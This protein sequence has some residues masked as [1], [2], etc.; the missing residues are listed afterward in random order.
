M[1]GPAGAGIAL[2]GIRSFYVGGANAR[3]DLP[4]T[5]GVA[6]ALGSDRRA[7][8]QSGDYQV[9]QMYVQGF[10]NAKADGSPPLLMWHGGGMTGVTWETTP[11]GRPGWLEHALIDGFDVYVSDAVERGRSSFPPNA[12]SEMAAVF[13]PKQLAWEIFRMGPEGGYASDPAARRYFDGQRFPAGDYDAFANQ[14]VAR[15][16]A[17]APM[18]EAAYAE[19]LGHFEQAVIVAHSQGCGYAQKA[20]Q[21][22]TAHVRA[23]VLVEPSG[24]PDVPDAACLARLRAVPHLVVWGDFFDQSPVWQAYRR[25]VETYLDALAAAGV[26]VDVID[27]PARGVAGNSHFPMMDD[28]SAAVWTLVRDWLAQR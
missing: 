27:L 26:P 11:D 28:N 16:P 1:P 8:D 14:F 23:V 3:L 9:G 10:L 12:V 2:R 5:E 25:T 21:D 24:S 6:L 15:W 20:A 13:R 22:M 4:P 19:Y 18:V 17:L 7:L